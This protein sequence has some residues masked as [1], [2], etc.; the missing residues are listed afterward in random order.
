MNQIIAFIASHWLGLVGTGTVISTGIALATRFIPGFVGK[1]VKIALDDVVNLS[2]PNKKALALAII[3]FIDSEFSGYVG[4]DKYS[5]AAAALTRL[6][7]MLVPCQGQIATL[8]ADIAIQIKSD[9]DS[10]GSP[11]TA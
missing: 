6:V 5:A 11:P 4:P 2:N 10:A 9:L 7:P 1:E 8:I 3:K